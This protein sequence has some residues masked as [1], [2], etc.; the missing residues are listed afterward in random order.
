MR[1]EADEL[2][3]Q[4]VLDLDDVENGDTLD[5]APGGLD[6]ASATAEVEAEVGAETDSPASAPRKRLLALARR[7]EALRPQDRRQ[8]SAGDRAGQEAPR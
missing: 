3:E 4:S 1:A 6:D 2:G 5:V 7:A 8:V